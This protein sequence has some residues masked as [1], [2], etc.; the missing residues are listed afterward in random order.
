MY[1]GGNYV[2]VVYERMWKKLKMCAYKGASW[3]DL[4]IG[5]LLKWHTCETCKELKG[6]DSWSTT[7]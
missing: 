2:R 7:E 6:H 1:L 4:A 3:L 5:K